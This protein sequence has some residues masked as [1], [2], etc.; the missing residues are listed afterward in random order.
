MVMSVNQALVRDTEVDV[1]A[2]D[3]LEWTEQSLNSG[4]GPCL[5][6]GM[7]LVAL[8]DPNS[9]WSGMRD[10]NEDEEDDDGSEG[11]AFHTWVRKMIALGK[12][13]KLPSNK[14]VTVVFQN[15]EGA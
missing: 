3:I 1:K 15:R 6:T 13:R 10:P 9:V 8:R 2:G 4:A 5:A 11:Y 7:G 14:V 12:L